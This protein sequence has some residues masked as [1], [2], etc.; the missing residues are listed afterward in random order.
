MNKRRILSFA[1]IFALALQIFSMPFAAA[2]QAAPKK[3]VKT[4]LQKVGKKTYYYNQKGKKVTN[5]WKTVKGN[6]YYFGKNGAACTGYKKIKKDWYY[7]DKNCRMVRE[8]AVKI[9]GSRYYFMDNGKAPKRAVRVKNG[10][11]WKTNSAGKMVKN[12]TK[13]AKG[14][15]SFDAF[16]TEAGQPLGSQR[17]PGCDPPGSYDGLYTYDNFRVSTVEMNGARTIRGVIELAVEPPQI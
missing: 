5:A 2:A 7:F 14:G 16:Q 17:T 1:L 11:I 12:V 4:G 9:K 6:R 13:Y 3:T 10:N 15:K 8:K